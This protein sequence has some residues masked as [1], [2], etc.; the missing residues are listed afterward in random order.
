MAG[1]ADPIALVERHLDLSWNQGDV[2]ALDEVW[3]Q[4]AVVRL[5]PGL[6]LDGLDALKDH[7]RRSVAGY[8]ERKLTVEDVV[9]TDDTVAVR[10]TFEGLHAGEVLGVPATGRVL[11][12]TGMDFYRVAGGKLS[13][14]WIEV[15]AL[16]LMGQL[17][18]LPSS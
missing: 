12:V 14:E 13:E 9:A 10:W 18:L 2:D 15:D 16:G 4:D 1:G 8:G 7:L 3:A 11:R 17:G 6:V 5:S